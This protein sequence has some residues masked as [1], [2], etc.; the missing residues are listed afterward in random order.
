MNMPDRASLNDRAPSVAPPVA[1][2]VKDGFSASLSGA[3]L[4]DLVQM[5]C[6]SR[7]DGA[8]TGGCSCAAGGQEPSPVQA[9]ATN[10][11]GSIFGTTT[12]EG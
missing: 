9:L 10:K 4:P 11:M 7:T 8:I 2:P 6:L 12:S 5:A 1:S 3:C